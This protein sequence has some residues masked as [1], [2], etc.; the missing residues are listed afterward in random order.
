VFDVEK[1]L[2]FRMAYENK[3]GPLD[4]PII[5]GLMPIRDAKHA[6]FLQNEI[7][8]ITIPDCFMDRINAAGDQAAEVGLEIAMELGVALK[9]NVQGI[10]L[11]PFRRHQ[12]AGKIIDSI[13]QE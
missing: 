13:R 7:P 2:Q 8:G 4:V 10:Y 5:A 1:F 12:A 11:M 9:Q 3:Y 6:T